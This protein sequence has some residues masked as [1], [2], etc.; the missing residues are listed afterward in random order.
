MRRS[1]FL[2]A[3]SFSVTDNLNVIGVLTTFYELK[4]SYPE[5]SP[6]LSSSSACPLNLRFPPLSCHQNVKWRRSQN[7]NAYTFYVADNL[8]VIGDLTTFNVKM[9]EMLILKAITLSE[10]CFSNGVVFKRVPLAISVFRL[11]EID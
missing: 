9:V 1:P 6:V 3:N 11:D 5:I 2:K 4:D 10:Q 7:I 8:N